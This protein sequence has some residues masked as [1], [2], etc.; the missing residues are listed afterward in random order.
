M[1]KPLVYVPE[2][3]LDAGLAIVGRITVKLDPLL[4]VPQPVVT[5][6]G[7]EVAPTGTRAVTEVLELSVMDVELVPLNCTLV[8]PERLVPVM[9][10]LSRSIVPEEG[11]NEVMAGAGLTVAVVE[12]RTLSHPFP[13]TQHA[14]YEVVDEME[15]EVNAAPVPRRLPPSEAEYQRVVLQPDDERFTVPVPQRLPPVV[16]GEEGLLRMVI[17]VPAGEP[18]PMTAGLVERTRIRYCDPAAVPIR[19]RQLMGDEDP[20]PMIT[21][22]DRNEPVALDNCTW[23]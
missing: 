21:V 12:V 18:E 11:E 19:T 2:G 7:P 15:G 22:P 23:N 20:V 3:W 14:K 17:G 8:T 13:S 6:M 1:K 16:E 9:T 10:I 5:E 4:T